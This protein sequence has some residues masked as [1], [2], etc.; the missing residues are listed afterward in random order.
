MIATVLT[1]DRLS[2]GQAETSPA[3]GAVALS[4]PAWADQQIAAL[5][6]RGTVASLGGAEPVA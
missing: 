6:G 1:D 3:Y 4:R 2:R 5:S